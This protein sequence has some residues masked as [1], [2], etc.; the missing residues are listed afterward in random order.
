MTPIHT[1]Q[2]RGGRIEI[3]H[4][5]DCDSPREWDNLGTIACW[6]RRLVLCDVQPSVHPVDYFRDKTH[7]SFYLPVHMCEHGGIALSTKPFSCPWDSGQVGYIWCS[8]EKARNEW[9]LGQDADWNTKLGD[10]HGLPEETLG[11]RVSRVLEGEIDTYSKYLGGECYGYKAIASDGTELDS[12]LG[13]IGRETFDDMTSEAK[14]SIDRW[15][16]DET[17][18]NQDGEH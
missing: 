4:D 9:S 6:H 14:A 2:Y 7:D 12:C 15:F 10:A 16:E 17:N 8:L 3:Y 18:H 1:E 5:P 11:A 13:Y